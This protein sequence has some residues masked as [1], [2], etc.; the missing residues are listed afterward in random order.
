MV[1]DGSFA[2]WR[3]WL[4]TCMWCTFLATRRETWR[5]VKRYWTT[6]CRN[7]RTAFGFSSLR[8]A[9]SSWKETWR[10]L[11]NGT[12]GP[13]NRRTNG[14]SSITCV[15]GNWRGYI[16]IEHWL[17]TVVQIRC[18]SAVAVSNQSGSWH[19]L[20]HHIFWKVV[21]GLG[22]FIVTRKLYFCTRSELSL[23]IPNLW[24]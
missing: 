6:R 3:Y 24:W 21:V 20:T 9:W 18:I 19:C 11:L 14:L 2:W 13:G 5:Y 4:T 1:S 17:I 7:T 15:F 12:L 16:G 8:A 22:R 10:P 23:V